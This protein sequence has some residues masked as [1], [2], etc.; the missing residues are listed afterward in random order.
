MIDVLFRNKWVEVR[1]K[2]TE[3]GSYT[4]SHSIWCNGEGVAIL[5]FKIENGQLFILGRYEVCPCHSDEF[6]L[7]SI[8]GGMDKE[9]ESPA[10]TAKRELLEEGGYNVPL[11]KFVY[12]GTVKPSKQSD[13]IQHLFVVD[14]TGKEQGEIVGD[15]TFGEEGAYVKWITASELTNAEDPLLHTMFMRA[16]EQRAFRSKLGESN[17]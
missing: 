17:G 15:G 12:L 13:T 9:G 2:V 16:V 7:C 14:I 1:E 10:F 3:K 11:H 8:T 4:Y 6:E 5:P